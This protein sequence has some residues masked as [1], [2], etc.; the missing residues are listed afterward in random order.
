MALGFAFF[1]TAVLIFGLDCWSWSGSSNWSPTTLWTF[2]AGT[3]MAEPHFEWRGLDVLQFVIF[4][5]PLAA[6]FGAMGLMMIRW[7]HRSG[8]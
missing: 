4:H 2:W 8:W 7:G 3:G 6:L 1:L 5:F